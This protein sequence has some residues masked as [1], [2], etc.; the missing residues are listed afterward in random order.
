MPSNIIVSTRQIQRDRFEKPETLVQN[1]DEPADVI[2]FDGFCEMPETELKALYESLNLAMTFKD[3]Q[4]IQNYFVKDE[5]RDPTMT[6]IR[7]LDTFFTGLITAVI[8]LSP[9]S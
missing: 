8:L 5:H 9:Q 3:F 2:V 4:H 1:F 6:E 7:V